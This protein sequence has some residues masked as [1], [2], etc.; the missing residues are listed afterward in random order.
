LPVLSFYRR[1][2]LASYE[3]QSDSDEV[4]ELDDDDDEEE[5][6]EPP[7][8][9][10]RTTR[11]AVLRYVFI[12]KYKYMHKRAQVLLVNSQPTTKKTPAK[13]AAPAAKQKQLTFAPAGR[14]SRAAATKARGKMVVSF[15]YEIFL[16]CVVFHGHSLG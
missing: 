8:P 4:I 9:T 7:K 3:F 5:E 2:S 1:C 15:L 13:K 6:E 16:V 12:S 14:S 11:A 10:K